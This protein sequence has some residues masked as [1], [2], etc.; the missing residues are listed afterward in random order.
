[1]A[2]TSNRRNI[3]RPPPTPPEHRRRRRSSAPLSP[4]SGGA[5]TSSLRSASSSAQVISATLPRKRWCPHLIATLCIVVGAGHHDAER[6]DEVGAPPLAGE[7]GADDLR[8]DD[9]ERSDE[10]GAPPLAGESGAD[11]LRDDDAERSDEE[12][13]GGDGWGG[14]LGEGE[15]GEVDGVDGQRW[16]GDGWGGDLGEGEAGEVDGVDG[17]RWGGDGWAGGGALGTAVDDR[18][19]YWRYSAWQTRPV[20]EHSAQRSTIDPRTGV[21]RLGK[22]D[23]WRSTRHSRTPGTAADIPVHLRHHRPQQRRAVR[24]PQARQPTSLF[25]SGTT[26]RSK[27]VLCAHPRHGSRHPLGIDVGGGLGPFTVFPDGYSLPAIPLGIDVGGGLGPF[28]VFPDGYSLPAI[29]LGID[30]GQPDW[31]RVTSGG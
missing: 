7:S 22:H 14:D 19:T 30:V 25:T 4:A 27:G 28:T 1:M 11:D 8:D 9:A 6:S 10:V 31:C 2:G 13:W 29:P 3:D 12:R 18:S 16:G 15:A 5:P 23:R 20:A 21:T 24:A 17:Q 26:G